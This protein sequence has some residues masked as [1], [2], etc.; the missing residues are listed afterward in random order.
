MPTTNKSTESIDPASTLSATSKGAPIISSAS[1]GSP[2]VP[3]ASAALRETIARAKAARRDISKLQSKEPARPVPKV[4]GFHDVQVGEYNEDLLRNSVAKARTN[5]RLNI[6]A[7]RLTEMPREVMNM[8]S[9]NLGDGAWYESVDLIR[10]VAADNE[11][12][13]LE[14]DVFPDNDIGTANDDDDYQG[15]MFGGLETLDLHNNHLKVI[16]M[17]LR[18]LERLTTL[19]LSKNSLNNECLQIINQIL[20]LRE[21]R[22]GGNGLSG[23]LSSELCSLSNLEI[24]DLHDNALSA[25][26]EDLRHLSSLRVLNFAGNKVV[27]VPFH[28]LASLPLAELNV[29]RNRLSGSLFPASIDGLPHLKSLDAANN[30]LTSI[31]NDRRINLPSLQD[32]NVTENRLKTLP[33]I[34]GWTELLTLTAGGNK[35]TSFPQGTTSLSNLRTVDFSRNDLK[36]IDEQFGLMESLTVLRVAN[37]PLRERKFLTMDTGEMKRELRSRLQPANCS[38]VQGDDI[39]SYDG[40]NPAPTGPTALSAWLVK[41]GILNQSSTKLETIDPS[42]LKNLTKNNDIKAMIL[43]HNLLPHIPPAILFASHTLTS[44]DV[45]HNKLSSAKYLFTE[46]SLPRLKTLDASSNAVASLSPLVEYLAAPSLVELNVS[47]NRLTALPPLREIFP[48]LTTVYASDNKISKLL[49]E[50]VRGLQVLDVSGNDINHLEPKLGLLEGEGLRTLIVGG[51]TFKVPRRDV[52]DKGTG[53]V[54]AWLKSR[55]PEEEMVGLG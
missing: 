6:A 10:L 40:S 33:D 5:G 28:C 46:M 2:K 37:N 26:S 45:S 39:M 18:R 13:L 50:S 53:T 25:L 41:S 9:S 4:I 19:N 14:D 12:E 36:M 21:I 15:N 29:A 31:T 34:S 54:L 38:D 24:L 3:A 11:F 43:H 44:L 20:A 55:M 47:R 35:L 23:T 52:I 51:N 16:P 22:L 1:P 8:Y 27:S 49:V 32:L 17:G 42:D 30:A 7:L 48:S